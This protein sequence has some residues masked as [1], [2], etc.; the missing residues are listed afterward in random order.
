M[1]FGLKLGKARGAKQIVAWRER[2]NNYLNKLE[3]E[4]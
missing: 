4:Y 3:A 2:E 1:A